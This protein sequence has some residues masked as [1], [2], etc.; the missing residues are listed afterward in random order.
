MIGKRAANNGI[1]MRL[2]G[3]H[4]ARY[5]MHGLFR[6]LL[7]LMVLWSHTVATFFPE[8]GSWFG[9]LQLGNVAVSA[10][11]VLSGYLMSEAIAVWYSGRL[12]QFIA[13]RYLRISP[14]LL[15]AAVVSIAVHFILLHADIGMVGTEKIS[16]G[17]ISE[18]NA[19]LALLEPLFPF[20]IPIAKLAGLL[21]AQQPYAFVRYAWAIFTE[22]IFYWSLVVYFMSASRFGERATSFVFIPTILVL[23]VLGAGSY[24][25]FFDNTSAGAIPR[26]PLVSHMQWAPH[27]LIGFM[28]SR[29]GR[30]GWKNLPALALLAAASL[31]AIIQLGLYV[32][33]GVT[34]AMPVLAL[35][36]VT[37][38]AGFWMILSD[39]REYAFGKFR[40]TA[41][42]DSSLGNLSY[43][44]YINQFALALAILSALAYV[45]GTNVGDLPIPTRAVLF[46]GT[47][48]VVI[49]A[50]AALISL[51][52]TI[53]DQLRDRLR[54]AS[55]SNLK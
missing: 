32:R 29:C 22:L 52:D 37:L 50:A 25:G 17:A 36:T 2:N 14:P 49:A 11:F 4:S 41:K 23:F 15:V 45:T 18:R 3:D 13:N 38:I 26:I 19:M 5:R 1:A 21:P 55:I 12:P 9:K 7:A 33:S 31:L 40:F 10:F 27:F 51:T 44:I 54:G 8:S 48:V 42:L 16:D 46:V 24:N 20:N 28:L 34:G 6:F 43:P 30:D 35:Y 39:R 53:T 47:N